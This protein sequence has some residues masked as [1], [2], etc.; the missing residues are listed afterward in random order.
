MVAF[1][2]IGTIHSPFARRDE[3]PIQ[4]YRSQAAGQVELLPAHE[5]GLQDLEGF[6]HIFL[7]YTFHGADP[8]FDLR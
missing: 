1:E 3:T 6:S 2:P 7:L 4:P 8:G 5:A